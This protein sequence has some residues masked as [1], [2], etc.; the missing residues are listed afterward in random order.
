MSDDETKLRVSQKRKK[1][2]LTKVR[3]VEE[4]PLFRKR[5]ID[6]YDRSKIKKEGIEYYDE[7]TD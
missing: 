6:P 5:K 2:W 1:D 3:K 7:E 4:D